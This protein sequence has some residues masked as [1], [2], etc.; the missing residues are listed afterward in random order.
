MQ[1]LH[2]TR[3]GAHCCYVR[4]LQLMSATAREKL[5][6]VDQSELA[7]AVDEGIDGAVG[8]EDPLLVRCLLMSLSTQGNTILL[9]SDLVSQPLT[10]SG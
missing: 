6:V 8:A 10:Y 9:I 3:E 4:G 1:A 7:A 2:L 5:D